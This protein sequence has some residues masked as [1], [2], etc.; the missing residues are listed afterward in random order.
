[1]YFNTDEILEI[2]K[3]IEVNGRNYYLAAAKASPENSKWLIK[4][5]DEETAHELVF[6]KFQKAFET[7]KQETYPDPDNLA[8]NYLF[9]IADSIIFDLAQD[10]NEFFTGSETI[11]DIIKDAIKR[12]QEAINRGL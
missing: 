11:L 5:A 8:L 2:A 3:K 6:S 4:M 12:E 10:P 7:E 9:S 1:M